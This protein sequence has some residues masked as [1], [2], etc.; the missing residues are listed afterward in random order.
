[1]VKVVDNSLIEDNS[2]DD[3]YEISLGHIFSSIIRN[4]KIVLISTLLGISIS[5]IHAIFR[6]PVFQGQFQIVLEDKSEN[7][8]SNVPSQV[9]QLF[10][11]GLKKNSDNLQTTTKILESPS[12]LAPIYSFVK[13]SKI[14]NKS[15]DIPKTFRSWKKKVDI[16]LI[17]DTSVLEVKYIDSD[18]QLIK[19][20]LGKISISYQEFSGRDRKNSREKTSKT[21]ENQYQEMLVKANNSLEK[22]Q[23]FSLDNGLGIED[24]LPASD[25]TTNLMSMIPQNIQN[26]F[27]DF[28]ASPNYSNKENMNR[29]KTHFLK[30][31]NLEAEYIEK[32]SLLKPESSIMKNLKK[33]IKTLKDSISRPKEVLIEYRKLKRDAL[34]DEK[35]LASLEKQILFY[36]LTEAQKSDPWELISNP[37]I[38]GQQ[39]GISKRIIVLYG[40]LIGLL[41]G[42]VLG[43]IIDKKKDLIFYL[44]EFK[45]LIDSDYLIS[46]PIDN[47]KKSEAILEIINQNYDISNKSNKDLIYCGN[48]NAENNFFDDFNELLNSNNMNSIKE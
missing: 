2:K 30:L 6:I 17:K 37:T 14:S 31:R 18:K 44:D 47:L 38:S 7:L 1:M 33:Q 34:R 21:L 40:I 24:G 35:I 3:F 4:K 10:S 32:S 20:V 27:Q 46:I 23:E 29:Y 9:S 13:E 45:K 5:T 11:A 28:D 15:I 22:L 16:S 48:K 8:S 36:K 26:N 19:D 12:V 43:L 25:G 41:S 42:A 39:I